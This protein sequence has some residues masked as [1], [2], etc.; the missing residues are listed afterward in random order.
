MQGWLSHGGLLFYWGGGGGGILYEKKEVNGGV[1][2]QLGV[3]GAVPSRAPHRAPGIGAEGSRSCPEHIL[4][5]LDPAP[6]TYG[7]SRS[8]SK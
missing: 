6:S 4:G 8:C 7:E 5:G 2:A 3:R 1:P